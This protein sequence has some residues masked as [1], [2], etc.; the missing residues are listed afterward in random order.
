[1]LEVPSADLIA[2]SQAGLHGYGRCQSNGGVEA[3]SLAMPTVDDLEALLDFEEMHDLGPDSDSDGE[4][5]GDVCYAEDGKTPE[6]GLF[7]TA[8]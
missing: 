6:L 4:D 3:A 7:L 5:S 1:M 2:S 8:R